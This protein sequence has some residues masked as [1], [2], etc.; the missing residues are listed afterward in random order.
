VGKALGAYERLLHCGPSRFDRWANGEAAALSRSE[1]RGAALF[2]GKGK[3][4]NC[5]SGPYLSDEKFHNVG[6]KPGRVATVFIDSGDVGAIDGL[7]LAKADPLNV[8][9][10]FSDAD[11]GRLPAVVGPE[12]EGA[13]RTPRLRCISKHP[14][15][16]HTGQY[17]SLADVVAFFGH[18]GDQVG[19]PGKSELDVVGLTP[20]ERADVVAFLE[21]LEG[22]GPE[23]RLLAP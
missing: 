21:A 11:D 10:M 23:A 9:G 14:S 15:F 18:G 6:L 20:A 17:Q 2:V 5:H 7:A 3:C 12:L 19:F 8:K 22:P 1:Q 16:M 13:F 4:A